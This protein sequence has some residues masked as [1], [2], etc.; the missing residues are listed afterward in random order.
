MSCSWRTRSLTLW[1][2]ESSTYQRMSRLRK[3]SRRCSSSTRCKKRWIRIWCSRL[4]PLRIRL[5]L[6]D[7]RAWQLQ[8]KTL[9]GIIRIAQTKVIVLLNL[10]INWWPWGQIFWRTVRHS[11]YRAKDVQMLYLKSAKSLMKTRSMMKAESSVQWSGLKEKQKN[12]RYHQWWTWLAAV[13][14]K[15]ATKINS[16]LVIVEAAC[17]IKSQQLMQTRVLQV[18]QAWTGQEQFCLEPFAHRT[19][20]NLWQSKLATNL[21]L[22]A[23]H[24]V[25]LVKHLARGRAGDARALLSSFRIE[26]A[27]STVK[28]ARARCLVGKVSTTLT[29]IRVLWS[30]EIRFL[31]PSATMRP[32]KHWC[33]LP[34][35]KR[36]LNNSTGS[37]DR[38]RTQSGTTFAWATLTQSCL[39]SPS[40]KPKKLKNR[41]KPRE[42]RPK[43]Y[44]SKSSMMKLTAS[45][46]KTASLLNRSSKSAQCFWWQSETKRQSWTARSMSSN[47]KHGARI[48]TWSSYSKTWIKSRMITPS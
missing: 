38:S 33:R 44:L 8:W 34:K 39:S 1:R 16:L 40:S 37:W 42:P 25:V 14:M 31:N 12:A 5:G 11:L 30:V 46:R 17:L 26:I 3:M 41:T 20:Q 32:V 23:L 15:M 18:T 35:Q 13:V 28:T 10:L 9:T 27:S 21:S 47:S 43:N 45:E 2:C 48:K 36:Q 6:R 19:L 29:M 7:L 22:K 4:P 24:L